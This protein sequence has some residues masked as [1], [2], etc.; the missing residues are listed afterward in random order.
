M[1]TPTLGNLT[2]I[3]AGFAAAFLAALWLSLI[4]WTYRDI[5]SRARDPLVRI[6]A[7]LV[8]TILFLPGILI[9]IIL[10]P[11]RTL[12]DEYQ[13]SLEE[14]TLLQNIEEIPLC[15]GCTRRT[16][17]DWQLCPNCHTRLKKPCRGCGRLM[18][19]AW[20]LCPYCGAPTPGMRRE[21][22]SIEDALQ[23]LPV[24]SSEGVRTSSEDAPDSFLIT[25]K[26]RSNEEN[27]G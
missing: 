6:L 15:P 2:L 23:N 1:D 20:N 13:R 26:L 9:Y 7:L 24:E 10:R 17:A 18:D 3:A 12:D 25:D 21:S 8:V 27:P 4:F 14:E 19:L 16:Q 5:R 22:A 11:A